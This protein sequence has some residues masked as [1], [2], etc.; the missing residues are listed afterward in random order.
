MTFISLTI[1]SGS[2]HPC[3]IRT[4]PFTPLGWIFGSI[5]ILSGWKELG[6]EAEQTG[7]SIEICREK[8]EN[9]YN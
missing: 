9:K 7:W 3:P 2:F 8:S 6:S 4:S 5:L 1:S